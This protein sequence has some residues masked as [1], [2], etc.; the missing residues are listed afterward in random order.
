MR[1]TEN[2]IPNYY[3]LEHHLRESIRTG[4][5]KPG[6]PVPPNPS[7]ASSSPSVGRLS[8]R[9]WPASCSRA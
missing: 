6:D 9:A 4:A 3:R 1:A 7:S 5:L 2:F 8:A